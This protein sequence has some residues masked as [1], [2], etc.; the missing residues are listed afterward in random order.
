MTLSK[1]IEADFKDLTKRPRRKLVFEDKE[2]ETIFSDIEAISICGG[3]KNGQARQVW[4]N[5]HL[6]KETPADK[7]A[8]HIYAM[9]TVNELGLDTVSFLIALPP[10]PVGI[11]DTSKAFALFDKIKDK[12]KHPCFRLVDEKGIK[13]SISF[14]Y[15]D[16][17][18]TKPIKHESRTEDS[19]MM[20]IETVK[21]TTR[22]YDYDVLL[23]QSDNINLTKIFRDGKICPVDDATTNKPV[24]ELLVRFFDNPQ[25][26]FVYYG[27]TMSRCSNCD[28]TIYK[29]RSIAAAVGPVCARNLGL[30]W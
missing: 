18:E 22:T 7:F 17:I 2:I 21:V 24:I 19:Y 14:Y 8:A 16:V 3:I 1:D 20:W 13:Y 26:E 23:I 6:N 5:Y 15:T 28:K 30:K 11:G 25:K 10:F 29:E 4:K 12:K 9:N 27:T